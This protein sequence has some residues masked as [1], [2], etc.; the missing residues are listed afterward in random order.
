MRPFAIGDQVE[1]RA[2]FLR[3]VQWITNVPRRGKILEFLHEGR[4]AVVEFGIDELCLD[5]PSQRL[6]KVNVAN[7]IH[8][9]EMHKEPA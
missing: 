3:S 2:S 6:R 9:D 5:D 4:I 1:Y 8:R 7:L